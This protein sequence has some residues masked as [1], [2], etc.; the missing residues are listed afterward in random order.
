MRGSTIIPENIR[1]PAGLQ[2]AIDTFLSLSGTL[3]V[4]SDFD[5]VLAPLVDDPSQ[6]RPLEASASSLA[7]IQHGQDGRIQ[8][9]L[10]SGRRINELAQLAAP[11]PGMRLY[12]T[13]GAESGI[14]SDSGEL[15]ARSTQLTEQQ[16]AELT[17]VSSLAHLLADSARGAWVEHKDTSIVLHTRLASSV[18]TERIE[19]ELRSFARTRNVHTMIGHDVTEISATGASKGA[20]VT[21]LRAELGAVGVLYLGDDVTDE[22]VFAVLNGPD[23]GIKVGPGET[24]ATYRV[25]NPH[26][27]GFVLSYIADKVN[28]DL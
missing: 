12:G 19:R 23:I 20:S 15:N 26:E 17:E 5:G 18:D 21:A 27:V 14:I 10:V 1:W 9:A 13:H 25:E 28:A 11:T 24:A 4:A 7:A 22:T 2:R 8:V 16:E 6:S 3:I